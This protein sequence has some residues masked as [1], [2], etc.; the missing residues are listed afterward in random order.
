M[1][2]YYTIT[3]KALIWLGEQVAAQQSLTEVV[4]REKI[5]V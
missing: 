1:P 3:V 5:E 4:C 2:V